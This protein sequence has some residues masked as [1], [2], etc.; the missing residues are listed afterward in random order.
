MGNRRD[1]HIFRL[2]QLYTALPRSTSPQTQAQEKSI[3]QLQVYPVAWGLKSHFLSYLVCYIS[4][5]IVASEWL[6]LCQ[7]LPKPLIEFD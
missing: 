4:P 1:G 3:I 6:A 7:R 5:Q 2:I